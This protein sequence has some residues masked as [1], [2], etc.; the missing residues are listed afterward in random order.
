MLRRY[1]LFLLFTLSFTIQNLCTYA[2]FSGVKWERELYNGNSSRSDYCDKLPRIKKVI[3]SAEN[4]TFIVGRI[5]G[6]CG[7]PALGRP[8]VSRVDNE[9]TILWTTWLDRYWYYN[10]NKEIL[11][12]VPSQDGGLF[13]LTAEQG[14]G[15]SQWDT[16]SGYDFEDTTFYAE[17]WTDIYLSKIS[18]DGIL[19]WH[20]SIGGK[21]EDYGNSLVVDPQGNVL[22]AGQTFSAFNDFAGKRRYVDSVTYWDDSTYDVDN[23]DAFVSKISPTG[24]LLNV[25]CYGGS[26]SDNFLHIQNHPTYGYVVAGYSESNDLDLPAEGTKNGLW[27]LHLDSALNIVQQ[28]IIDTSITAGSTFFVKDNKMYLSSL[29]KFREIG[30]D[31]A[32]TREHSSGG[33]MFGSN[34]YF[35]K[36]GY[37]YRP[38]SNRQVFVYDSTLQLVDTLSFQGWNHGIYSIDGTNRNNLYLVGIERR[39]Q[40]LD[41]FVDGL[42]T[43]MMYSNVVMNFSEQYNLVTGSVYIDY[44]NNGLKDSGENQIR[45]IKIQANNGSLQRTILP[46]TSGRYRLPLDS[47]NYTIQV[48][49]VFPYHTV[50]PTSV[51]LQF[52]AFDKTDTINFALQPIPNKKDLSINLLPLNIARPGFPVQYQLICTNKGTEI[53]S[54]VQVKFV[55]NPR[56]SFVSSSPLVTT[57]VGDTLIWNIASMKPFDTSYINLD[58]RI[59]APPAVNNTDTLLFRSF[60]F[61]LVADETPEDNQFNLVQQVQGSY[62][63]NDKTETHGGIITPEQ[64]T[65]DE[66]LTYLIRFQ[67]TGTDTAFT[68]MIRDTLTNKLDWSSFEMLSSSHPYQLYMIKPHILE[69]SFPNILLVDSNKNEPASH[70]FVAYRIKPKSNLAVGDTVLN[71]AHIYFDYNLPVITNDELTVLRNT[72]I[73]S[74]I[75]ID[76]PDNQLLLYPNP[77]NGLVTIFRKGRLNGNANL[78]II[79][80]NGKVVHQSNLGQIATEQ[81]NQS[82]DVSRLLKGMYIVRLHAGRDIYQCKVIIQ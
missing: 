9:G 61:P 67:N 33:V 4:H 52:R 34:C 11:E 44:N 35:D 2:Q 70:G 19:L 39:R 46:H 43:I 1:L 32:F 49:S 55:K 74:V 48:S 75:D 71:R 51:N 59:A 38:F 14:S 65:G 77:S 57:T 41:Y 64:L 78:Q 5:F 66:F 42:S 62:D 76:R 17:H 40:E 27:I 18:A 7:T 22:V 60:A 68:V 16:T 82:V 24:V 8:F 13:L 29:L 15:G 47:G 12:A 20:R 45:G 53:I 50:T 73:T 37:I 21:R 31:G 10:Y 56:V 30:A 58:L 25:K 36:T 26:S 54:N 23:N 69:F 63:P 72:V 80:M 28:T 81:F 6:E 3:H 79:D